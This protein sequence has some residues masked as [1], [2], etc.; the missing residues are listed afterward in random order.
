MTDTDS[1]KMTDFDNN[2]KQNCNDLILEQQK[3]FA[4]V[5]AAAK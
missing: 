2:M 1:K 5:L 4:K 3:T